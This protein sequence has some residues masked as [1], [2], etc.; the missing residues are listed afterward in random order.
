MARYE[1][2]RLGNPTRTGFETSIIPDTPLVG[3]GRSTWFGNANPS[4]T[5]IVRASGDLS[6]EPTIAL[7]DTEILNPSAPARGPGNTV[8][9]GNLTPGV[10]N[11]AVVR[12]VRN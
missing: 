5:V 3:P 6:G 10:V 11:D 12:L 8:W 9:F 7:L 1:G 2:D 4:G